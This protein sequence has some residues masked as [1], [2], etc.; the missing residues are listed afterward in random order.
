LPPAAAGAVALE[1][2]G[3]DRGTV[4]SAVSVSDDS[5]S[6]SLLPSHTPAPPFLVIADDSQRNN[7]PRGIVNNG[8]CQKLQLIQSHMAQK[9]VLRGEVG[10]M[11]TMCLCRLWV[12]QRI[13]NSK[14]LKGLNKWVVYCEVGKQFPSAFAVAPPGSA[15][16]LKSR[17]QPLEAADANSGRQGARLKKWKKDAQ[18]ATQAG[19]EL[20]A[21]VRGMRA[22]RPLVP[23]R[24]MARAGV[25][26]PATPVR[27]PRGT[28]AVVTRRRAPFARILLHVVC[29]C[30]FFALLREHLRASLT[31]PL[32]SSMV[33][34]SSSRSLRSCSFSARIA[35]TST[36]VGAPM[37]LCHT[38]AQAVT[39]IRRHPAV[40]TRAAFP[41][42]RQK[43]WSGEKAASASAYAARSQRNELQSEL[44]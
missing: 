31:R 39:G 5:S 38:T 44:L 3:H 34:R 24:E 36:P 12:K 35:S 33:D 19:A 29:M 11:S 43:S 4:R 16:L 28:T 7:K 9:P 1:E 2:A 25:L 21:K 37:Y 26:C 17:P 20:W 27:P 32:S 13:L 22:P 23:G 41:P 40:L 42:H 6:L 18:P 10:C 15:G 8:P 14:G 30:F